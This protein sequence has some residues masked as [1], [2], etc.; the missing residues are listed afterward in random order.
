MAGVKSTKSLG[1][2]LKGYFEAESLKVI[3]YTDDGGEVV[4]DLASV[5]KQFDKK[6][7]SISIKTTHKLENGAE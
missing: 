3:E 1:Y 5:F 7:V 4:H 6:D 2:S